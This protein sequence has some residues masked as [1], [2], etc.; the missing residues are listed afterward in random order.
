MSLGSISTLFSPEQSTYLSSS[1]T[2]Y[3]CFGVG[4][5][6]DGAGD[7]GGDGGVVVSVDL[8]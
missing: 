8:L 4:V 1:V 3:F 7:V 2:K 6:V 5:D